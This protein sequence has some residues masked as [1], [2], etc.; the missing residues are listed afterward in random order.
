MALLSFKVDIIC[1]VH[2]FLNTW[3]FSTFVIC[4]VKW[5]RETFLWEGMEKLWKRVGEEE[6]LGICHCVAERDLLKWS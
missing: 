6:I 3:H 1:V 5:K 2:N 4:I